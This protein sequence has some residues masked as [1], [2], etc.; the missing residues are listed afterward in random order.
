VVDPAAPTNF[1][2]DLGRPF[3]DFSGVTV[4]P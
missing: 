3:I 2:A 1:N 4:L